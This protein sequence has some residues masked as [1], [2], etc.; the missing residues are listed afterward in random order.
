M[1]AFENPSCWP[2]QFESANTCSSHVYP[3][4]WAK[5]VPNEVKGTTGLLGMGGTFLQGPSVM[6]YEAEPSASVPVHSGAV[7]VMIPRMVLAARASRRGVAKA[8]AARHG[9]A[10]SSL[11]CF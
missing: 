7:K 6:K 2:V 1:L 4:G 3:A 10:M 8:V 9:R 11:D 5:P